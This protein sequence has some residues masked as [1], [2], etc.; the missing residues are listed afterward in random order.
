MAIGAGWEGIVV[1]STA[2]H[3]FEGRSIADIAEQEGL[4]PVE[5]LLHVL[6]EEQLQATM[7]VH[8]MSEDDVITALED[9]FTMIG[10]D[11]LPPGTGGRPHPRM[12]GTFPRIIA[13]F[14]RDLGVLSA[15][16]AIRRMTSLPADT[17][18]LS[19]R[20]VI[21]QGK[22]ADL[23]AFV[24]ADV[25]DTATF[26]DP[27]RFPEGMPWVMVNGQVVVEGAQYVGGRHGRRVKR[28]A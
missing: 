6:R 24:P 10:S 18:G 2:D 21:A 13:R 17:F 5:A 27:V 8:Q 3:Q 11:G 4:D 23:V 28:G 9:P 25:Q 16:E 19:D 7:T 15:A 26:E 14:S 22:K 1:S 12:Y 20:G